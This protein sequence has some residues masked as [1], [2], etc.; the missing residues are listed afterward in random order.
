MCTTFQG[1]KM[2]NEF[3]ATLG[4]YSANMFVF[5]TYIKTLDGS[6]NT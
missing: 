4:M 2:R 5:Q 6:F 3:I 1:Y